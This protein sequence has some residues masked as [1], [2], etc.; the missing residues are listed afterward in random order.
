LSRT[1]VGP[2]SGAVLALMFDL[3]GK[4]VYSIACASMVHQRQMRTL[5]ASVVILKVT[6]A[7]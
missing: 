4:L 1:L 6:V 5:R 3:L 7:D 2:G